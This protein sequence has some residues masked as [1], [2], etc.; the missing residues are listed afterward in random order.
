[1]PSAEI[2]NETMASMRGDQWLA[3]LYWIL[4]TWFIATNHEIHYLY[5]LF[6]NIKNSN[7]LHSRFCSFLSQ[8][9]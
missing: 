3:H 9:R 8:L 7:F 2:M 5:W 4:T 6:Y 1:M